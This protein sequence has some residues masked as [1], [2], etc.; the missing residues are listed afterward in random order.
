MMTTTIRA[1]ET[2]RKTNVLLLASSLW[3]GGAESVIQ[4]LAQTLDRRRF[5]VTVCCLK[6]RGQIGAELAKTGIDVVTFGDDEAPKDRGKPDYFT[7]RRLA[8][9]L[10]ARQI[11]VVHSHTTHG[12][13]DATLCKLFVP[14]LKVVH[15][16]HFGNYPHTRP[17]IIWMERMFSRRADRLV[18]VGNVQ[19]TQLQSVYGFNDRAIGTIWNGVDTA[20][21]AGDPALLA[22]FAPN[23]RVVIGTIATFIDQKGLPDLMRAARRVLDAGHRALF[24]VVGEGQLRPQLED[25]RRQLGLERDVL[26]PGW[27]THAAQTALPHFDV[28][29]QPSLWE[30]MSMVVLEAMAAGKATVATR[31]GENPHMINPESDGLLVNVGDVEGMAQ[32]LGRLIADTDLRTRLGANARRAIERRFT[33]KHMT[34]AYE[35]VY[36]EL[37]GKTVATLAG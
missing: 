35:Q 8:S 2:G 33:I 9:L 5:N 25:L 27:I 22:Q 13:V 26:L 18:A 14:H 19:R 34:A 4:H 31:V 36:A 16:F 7:F 1:S 10:R 21:A 3:I 6:Q 15:T 12:L 24:V 28:F 20:V 11:D 30:A 29:F 17:R 32:A 23:G 37:C